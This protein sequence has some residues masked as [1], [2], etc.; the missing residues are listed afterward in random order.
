[1]ASFEALAFPAGVSSGS[2]GIALAVAVTALKDQVALLRDCVRPFHGGT[3]GVYTFLGVIGHA[4]SN[5][6]FMLC[7]LVDT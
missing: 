2:E 1:V 5:T 3:Y 7:T 6:L 4:S